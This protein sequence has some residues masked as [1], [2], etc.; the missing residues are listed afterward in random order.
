VQLPQQPP[1]AQQA[2][3][4]A[5]FQEPDYG[6]VAEEL[7][8]D[9]PMTISEMIAKVELVIDLVDE[10]RNKTRE[11]AIFRTKLQEAAMWAREAIRKGA[12]AISS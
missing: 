8:E 11:M 4:E 5:T 2:L 10:Y 7:P 3:R 9:K 6:G 12:D 1:P